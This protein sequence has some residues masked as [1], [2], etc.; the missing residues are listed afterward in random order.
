MKIIILLTAIPKNV[1]QLVT[2]ADPTLFRVLIESE[3]IKEII[4]FR[5]PRNRSKYHNKS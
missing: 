1:N 3:I 2:R 5:K 4:S